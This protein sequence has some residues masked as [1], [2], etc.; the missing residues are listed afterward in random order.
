ATAPPQALERDPGGDRGG[1]G[2]LEAVE[3]LR[4]QDDREE[5]REER[6]DGGEERGP[7]GPDA[8]DRREP[9][10]VREEQRP[11]HR[12]AEPEPDLPAEREGFVAELDRGERGERHPADREDEGA[13]P[14]RRVA[15]H[16]RRDRHRV[17]APRERRRDR[18]QVSA[19]RTAD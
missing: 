2:E 6:L 19:E 17:T 9:E 10:D 3:R 12:V 8:R 16:E 7:R 14:V 13:D 4:E 5:H 18:D 15:L 1:A 11:D